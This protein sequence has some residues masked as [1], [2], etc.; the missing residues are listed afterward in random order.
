M[1]ELIAKDPRNQEH[2]FPYIGGEEINSSPTQAHGRFVI[3]FGDMSELEARR[4][5]GLVRILEERVRPERKSKSKDV[6]ACPWWQFWRP[7]DGLYAA[8]RKLDRFLAISSRRECI[9]MVFPS[10]HHGR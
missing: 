1:E 3:Y 2:I 7:R 9:R 5:P 10:R 8:I 4:W 6:A